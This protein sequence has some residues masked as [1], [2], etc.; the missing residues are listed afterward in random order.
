MS[1]ATNTLFITEKPIYLD[2]LLSDG[3]VRVHKAMHYMREDLVIYCSCLQMSC[4][5]LHNMC[6][7]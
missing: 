2:C 7:F 1:L 6:Q 5:Q 3:W 4:Q